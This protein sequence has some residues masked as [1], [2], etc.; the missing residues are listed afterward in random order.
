M[1]IDCIVRDGATDSSLFYRVVKERRS[2]GSSSF[3]S[4]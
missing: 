3:G 2:A 1:E 4:W